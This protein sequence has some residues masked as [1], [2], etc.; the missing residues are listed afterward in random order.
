VRHAD[1]APL[2]PNT[3][4]AAQ[5]TVRPGRGTNASAVCAHWSQDLASDR[6]GSMCAER[7]CCGSGSLTAAALPPGAPTRRPAAPGRRWLR[8]FP[9]LDGWVAVHDRLSHSARHVTVQVRPCTSKVRRKGRSLCGRASCVPRASAFGMHA[10]QLLA[11][12]PHLPNVVARLSWHR[13]AMG[14]VESKVPHRDELGVTPS[15][16]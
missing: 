13:G 12:A 4:R 6:Q 7:H 15:R 1:S 9:C 16:P 14:L 8:T 11:A 3:Q 10:A 5:P 2:Q